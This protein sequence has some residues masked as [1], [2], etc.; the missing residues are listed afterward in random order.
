MTAEGWR[1]EQDAHLA[2]ADA[3]ADAVAAHVDGWESE[4]DTP[5]P[6]EHRANPKLVHTAT[7]ARVYVSPVTY[8]AGGGVRVELSAAVPTD[9]S[10][11]AGD[12]HGIDRPEITVRSDRA[13][14]HPASLARDVERR[15]LPAAVEYHAAVSG[16]IARRIAAAN[17]RETMARELAGIM[18]GNASEGRNGTWKASLPDRLRGQR[19]DTAYTY[20]DMTPDSDGEVTVEIRNMTTEEAR[21]LAALIATWRVG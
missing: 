20:G 15:L 9:A 6:G 4:H 7:G 17:A 19:P 1:A 8:G 16:R 21:E 11:S 12:Y 5:E 14:D 18:G 2:R 3:V 10:H 13:T